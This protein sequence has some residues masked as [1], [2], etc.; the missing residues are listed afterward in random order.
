MIVAAA[1]GFLIGAALAVG[2]LL[3]LL[4]RRT[5][6]PRLDPRVAELSELAG[7]LAHELRNPLSTI[8]VNLQLLAE[9]LRDKTDLE[10]S[11]RRAQ[12]KV[13]AV[14]HEAERLRHLLDDFLQMAGPC[15]LACQRVDLNRIVEHLMEFFSPQA[16]TASVRLRVNCAEEALECFLDRHLIEQA[17]LNLLLNAQQAMPDGG[18]VIIRTWRENDRTAGVEVSDTGPGV[19]PDDRDRIFRP[20]YSTKAGGTGLGLSTAQRIVAEHDGSLDLHSEPGR[21]TRFTILLPL[22]QP[23]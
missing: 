8:M 14:R 16:E 4:R 10:V 9:D 3:Y 23:G 20:F 5:Q 15:R 13:D 17:L 18:E 2:V 22:A 12:I 7:G 11:H 6:P 1:A 19:S 21:G